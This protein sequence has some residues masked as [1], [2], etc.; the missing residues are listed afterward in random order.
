[1]W[2]GISTAVDTLILPEQT[3][4]YWGVSSIYVKSEDEYYTGGLCGIPMYWKNE[5]AVILDERY[6]EVWQITKSDADVYAVGL[7]NKHNSNSSGHTA[8]YWKNGTLHELD[9][10]AQAYGIFIDGDD[11]YVSGAIGIA[12][13]FYT[14]CYWKNGVRVDLPF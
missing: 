9:D 2:D 1:M 7:V 10:N 14:S 8:S 13:A 12:P 4:A 6:G 11:V 3:V 5:E